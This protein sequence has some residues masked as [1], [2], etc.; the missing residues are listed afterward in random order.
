MN[1][2]RCGGALPRGS[3]FCNGCG[4]QVVAGAAAPSPRSVPPAPAHSRTPHPRP[5][6]Q[7][8]AAAYAPG[9][10]DAANAAGAGE[11]GPSRR[12]M[13][14]LIAA[15]LL[16]T[17]GVTAAG[18]FLVPGARATVLGAVAPQLAASPALQEALPGDLPAAPSL[19]TGDSPGLPPSSPVTQG[20]SRPDEEIPSLIMA[21]GSRVPTAGAPVTAQE[22]APLPAGPN[23]IAGMSPPLP[24]GPGV[25]G[26][27]PPPPPVDNQDLDRYVRWLQYVEQERANLRAQAETESFRLFGSFYDSIIGL[28][29]PFANEAGAEQQI[30]Q[31][32]QQAFVRTADAIQ[33]FRQNIVRSKPPVPHD[34][35]AV[36]R[37]YMRAMDVE[38]QQTLALFNALGNRDIGQVRAIGSSS[39]AEID[40]NLTRADQELQKVF[41]GRRLNPQFKIQTGP[42]MLSGMIGMGFGR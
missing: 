21:P 35:Q 34:C 15:I 16:L 5:Q 7:P 38:G 2:A 1:C 18:I 22:R 33:K 4:A 9:A 27:Q 23:P 12:P 26:S 8:H 40:Q 14:L 11:V 13:M 28:S 30:Q 25:H 31:G 20:A 39:V 17:A 10:A 41:H 36:D 19:L 42:S 29:D 6:P 3:R 37:F 32:L 24:V